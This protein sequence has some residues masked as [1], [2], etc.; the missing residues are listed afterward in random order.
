MLQRFC[1]QFKA[2]PI[3]N[4]DMDDNNSI[5]ESHLVGLLVPILMTVTFPLLGGLKKMQPKRDIGGQ[6]SKLLY[7]YIFYIIS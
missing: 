2:T 7:H 3:V 4:V 5:Y 6:I 1:S